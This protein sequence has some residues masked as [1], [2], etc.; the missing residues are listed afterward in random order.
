MA[1]TATRSLVI[2]R[3]GRRCEYC[4]LPQSAYQFTF[5]VDHIVA[6][7]HGGDDAESNL[8]LACPRCNRRKG[9]NLSAIDPQDGGVVELFHPRRAHWEEHFAFV[10]AAIVGRTATGR[11][12]ALLLDMN[13]PDRVQARAVLIATGMM[14][15]E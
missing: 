11:A 12:T 1:S 7:Q 13:H 5:N 4:R 14:S 3:A 9:T 6:R 15:G 10:A 8:A 2:E